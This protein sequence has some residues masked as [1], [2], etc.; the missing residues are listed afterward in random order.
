ML[1]AGRDGALA[2]P[3]FGDGVGRI[4]SP[5]QAS[6]VTSAELRQFGV[7]R[8]RTAVQGQDRRTAGRGTPGL[9]G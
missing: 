6:I 1:V 3:Q 4:A 9:L 8:G 7:R 5:R 2:V